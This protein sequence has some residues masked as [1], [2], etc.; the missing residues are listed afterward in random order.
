MGNITRFWNLLVRLFS[1]ALDWALSHW[2]VGLVIM[3]LLVLWAGG[4]KKQK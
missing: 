4:L 1:E 3:A 2:I